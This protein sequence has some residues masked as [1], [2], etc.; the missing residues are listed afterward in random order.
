MQKHLKHS[1]QDSDLAS[2]RDAAAL[3]K[4]PEA[5]RAEW[6]KLWAEVEALLKKAGEAAKK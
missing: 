6:N 5:E 1:Q 2:V 4:L 3:A